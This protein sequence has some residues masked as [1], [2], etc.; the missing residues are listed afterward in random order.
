ML[1]GKDRGKTGK[2]LYAL[3]REE[4]IIIEGLNLVKKNQRP[5]KQDQKGQIISMPRAVSISSVMLIC[6]HC[7]K[8]SRMGVK[9]EDKKA[10]R[11]CK[12]CGKEN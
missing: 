5:K 12:K 9:Q 4:K 3:P 8:P 11:V 7:K 6:Q 10:V 1:S 2:I